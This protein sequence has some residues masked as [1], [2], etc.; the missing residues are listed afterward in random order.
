MTQT[1]RIDLENPTARVR[2]T[3]GDVFFL[4]MR[5]RT[6]ANLDMRTIRRWWEPPISIGQVWVFNFDD[7]PRA[8]LSWALLNEEAQAR[9]VSQKEPLRPEDWRSG[10]IPWLIDYIAPYKNQK[11][12]NHITG[13]LR[14]K[15]F[16][17]KRVRYMR[18]DAEGKPRRIVETSAGDFARQKFTFLDPS[19]LG[20]DAK[21]DGPRPH[22][23]RSG[24]ACLSDRP[25]A[26]LAEPI[27]PVP[28]VHAVGRPACRIDL[29]H[30]LRG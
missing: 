25:P 27:D 11:I 29:G 8:A 16:P 1:V 2:A 6:H 10:D 21:A 18:L 23:P 19:D 28:T 24:A 15:G 30:H 12:E 17:D 4:M 14:E 20:A 22:R 7:M 5:S 13:W 9:Y 3:M 26:L